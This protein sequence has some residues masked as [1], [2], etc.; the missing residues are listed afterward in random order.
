MQIVGNEFLYTY[1]VYLME[2][3]NGYNKM[4]NALAFPLHIFDM[5]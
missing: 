1:P 3:E 5:V 2:D 4:N